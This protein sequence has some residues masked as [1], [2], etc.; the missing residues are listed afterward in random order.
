MTLVA[1]LEYIVVVAKPN[2]IHLN[3]KDTIAY[4]YSTMGSNV[5]SENAG[6][7]RY[8]SVFMQNDSPSKCKFNF[9][10]VTLMSY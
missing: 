7:K 2:P 3:R 8:N 5:R 6:K 1:T 10:F 9:R 4:R